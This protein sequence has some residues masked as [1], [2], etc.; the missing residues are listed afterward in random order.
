MP[1]EQPADWFPSVTRRAPKLIAQLISRPRGLTALVPVAQDVERLI[2]VQ[3]E[4]SCEPA[5]DPKRMKVAVLAGDRR[6]HRLQVSPRS[7]DGGSVGAA[8]WR[9]QRRRP[10]RRLG[11]R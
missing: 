10:G 9:A 7:L 4:T 5:A 3:R 1:S 2:V 8:R 11:R 6:R